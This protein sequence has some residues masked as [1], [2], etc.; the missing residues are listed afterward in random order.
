MFSCTLKKRERET[1]FTVAVLLI[2]IIDFLVTLDD[3]KVVYL[4]ESLI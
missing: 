4:N 3:L 2:L 1:R